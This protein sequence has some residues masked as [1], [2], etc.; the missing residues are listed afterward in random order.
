MGMIRIGQQ[1]FSVE[2]IIFD[3]DGTLIEFNHFW[4]PRTEQWVDAMASFLQLGEDFKNAVY[5]LI[6]YSLEKHQV[7]FESPL[8][9]ASM[10]IN[11]LLA[12]GVISKYGIP[13][14]Q[15]RVIAKNCAASTMLANLKL[16]EIAPKGDL[17]GVMKQLRDAQISV[18]VVTSDDRQMTEKSL[19]HLG[20]RDFVSVLV[21]GDDPVANKPE[22]DGIWAIAKQL[23]ISPDR[24]MMVGDS[25]SDMQFADNAG[26]AYRIAITSDPEA[27]AMLAA[28]ADAVISSVDE[29]NGLLSQ[30]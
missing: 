14:H 13:W 11:Y 2:C 12:S 17:V 18:A 21:C 19:D 16:G 22:P 4:G 8:A 15:A 23:S 1:V 6:G 27:A 20:I 25:L 29:L 5:D 26:I 9:V 10:E 24:I 30:Q 3:K 7:R 28:R